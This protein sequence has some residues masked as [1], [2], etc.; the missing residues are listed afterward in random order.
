[1]RMR[2]LGFDVWVDPKIRI[3]HEKTKIL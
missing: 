1:M 3:G 2:E